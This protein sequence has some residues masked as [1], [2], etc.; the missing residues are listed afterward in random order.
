MVYN[1]S[2]IENQIETYTEN[3]NDLNSRE[4][5][6]VKEFLIMH[7]AVFSNKP[8]CTNAYEY[9]INPTFEKP[10]VKNSYPVPLHQQA[11][12]DREIENMLEQGII[13]HLCSEYSNPI[14]I[15]KKRRW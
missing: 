9:A 8:G 15:V 5:E 12:I 2:S 1:K 3:L 7:P 6:T 4:K 13:E 14:R 10:F 11:A